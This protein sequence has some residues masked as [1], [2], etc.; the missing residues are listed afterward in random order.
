MNDR[1]NPRS[2]P[3]RNSRRRFLGTVGTAA[4]SIIVP[5]S[6]RSRLATLS[7]PVRLGMITDLHQDS[8]HDGPERL[9]RFL[10]AMKADSPDA[11]IQLGDFAVP[12]EANQPLI[13]SFNHAHPIAMHVL[14][15]HDADGGYTYA[16]TL[17]AWGM[18]H[19]YYYRDIDGLRIIVLDGNEKPPNH[20]GGY[21]SHIGPQQMDWLQ[22]TLHS[23]EGPILVL[24][25]QPLAGPWPVDNADDVQMVLSSAADRVL[26]AVNG[27][28]HLDYLVREK[29]VGYLHLNSASYVWVGRDF[30]RTTHSA[31]IHAA[32]PKLASACTYRDPLFTTL[33]IDP[34]TGRIDVQGCDS[35]WVGESPAERGRD[36]HP[37][38]LDGEQIVPKI[39]ARQIRRIAT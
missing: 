20:D 26:L 8:M 2:Q 39:R 5:E 16:Q 30:Q 1:R 38:L 13:D 25:H 32:Y 9:G 24:S 33:T 23:H 18:K 29:G 28:S 37:D 36:K 31:E 7:K 15:N 22:T 11:I 12:A 14:G 3:T 34:A 19:R 10:A 27:H 35:Q 21:P 4:A 17:A 6:A